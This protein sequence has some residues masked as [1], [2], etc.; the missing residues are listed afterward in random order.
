MTRCINKFIDKLQMS[1]TTS[2]INSIGDLFLTPA[3]HLFNGRSVTCGHNL[4]ASGIFELEFIPKEKAEPSN[5][6][7]PGLLKGAAAILLLLPCGLLGFLFKS[8]ALVCSKNLRDIYHA[9]S[10]HLSTPKPKM[11][12]LEPL[13]APVVVTA[14]KLLPSWL[15]GYENFREYVGGAASSM[16]Q[17]IVMKVHCGWLSTNFTH[18]ARVGHLLAHNYSDRLYISRVYKQGGGP[19][20]SHDAFLKDLGSHV[21]ADDVHLKLSATL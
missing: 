20:F 15:K 7:L 19:E 8:M 14:E 2:G 12:T 13:A 6:C 10:L 3:R 5:C 1:S 21:D 16:S 9:Y 17:K 4:N 11:S 18:P